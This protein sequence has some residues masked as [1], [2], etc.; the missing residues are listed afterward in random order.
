MH[1]LGT[2]AYRT[3]KA[4]RDAP[5]DF[6]QFRA[7]DAV[8]TP[9]EL[10]RHMTSVL[11]YA[12]ACYVG[13]TYGPDDLAALED[14]VSRFHGMLQDLGHHIDAGTE[15]RDGMTPERLLQ[16]PLADAMTHAGQLAMLRRLAGSPVRPEDFSLA[17]IQGT[18][19]GPDQADPV[20]PDDDRPEAPTQRIQIAIR[21]AT[22]ADWPAIVH[23]NDSAFEGPGES[24][25]IE[26]LER[27][28]RPVISLLA[29]ADGVP[30]GHVFFSP[31]SIQSAGARILVAALAP[32]AVSPPFQRRGIGSQLVEAGLR[33]CA[34]HAYQVVVVV[35]H[36]Q[37]YRRFGFTPAASLG[38]SSVYSDAGD[39]FMALEL[40]TGVLSG[41]AG[42]VEYS[43]E[44][45]NV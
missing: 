26:A 3:Q 32:M 28:N 14:E 42:V 5:A 19:L 16:G 11:G 40:T 13:G 9:S 7:A 21:P 25:L 12:R 4:L 15:L 29:L 39:A 18:R 17:D 41:R 44:F 23:I 2:L 10:V 6:G 8:R 33:A 31:V 1:F 35:G 34:D 37:F 24:A 38:L 43:A 45:A 27:S 20:S 30:A 22:P 36:P